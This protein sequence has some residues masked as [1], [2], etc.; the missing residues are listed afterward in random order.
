MKKENEFLKHKLDDLEMKN[1]NL[2]D[3]SRRNNLIIHGLH[4][5]RG[6]TW[7]ET[8]NKV[9][10]FMSS[11]DV[12]SA[13]TIS[14]ERAHRLNSKSSNRP[15]LVKFS[16]YKDKCAVLDATKEFRKH[17][18]LDHRVS[19][20][21]TERVRWLRSKLFPFMKAAR[22]KSETA[23]LSYDKL[24]IEGDVY[25]YDVAEQ[26]IRQVGRRRNWVRRGTT[27]PQQTATSPD[28]AHDTIQTPTQTDRK[29]VV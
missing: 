19:E 8:E 3:Q 28:C 14:I 20:D 9:R 25:V 21:C 12:A 22:D 7:A 15:T 13:G 23:F 24:I 27:T 26:D 18:R 11:L 17:D 4:E 10:S 16:F 6:E 1:D 2:E 29:S 5:K